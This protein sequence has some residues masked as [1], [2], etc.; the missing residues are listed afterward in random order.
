MRFNGE[1]R[2]TQASKKV[3][4]RAIKGATRLMSTN[5]RDSVV[6]FFNGDRMVAYMKGNQR[7]IAV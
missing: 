6:E 3:F 4:E 1:P 5:G 7:F 2:F